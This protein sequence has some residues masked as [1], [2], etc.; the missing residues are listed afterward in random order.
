MSKV[1]TVIL[2][3]FHP[4]KYFKVLKLLD[5]QIPQTLRKICEKNK[6]KAFTLWIKMHMQQ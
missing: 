2:Q 5:I 4:D 6:Q 1:F 3:K